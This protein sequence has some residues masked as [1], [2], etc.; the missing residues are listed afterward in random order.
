[1]GDIIHTLPAVASLKRSF[2]GSH[3]S[4]VVEPRWAP[5]LAGNLFV[6]RLILFDRSSV[7]GL[8]RSYDELRRDRFDFA[9]D[10]QGLI[11]SALVASAAGPARLFGFDRT[12]T[13]ETPAALFYSNSVVVSSSHVVDRNLELASAAG[14]TNLINVF[15]AAGG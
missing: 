1:M 10:F 3:I 14:A 15:S 12:Q 2:P 11:K 7:S 9:V 13:R 5:L 6:D 4:W 8:V